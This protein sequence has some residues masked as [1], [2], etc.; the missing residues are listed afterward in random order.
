M[1]RL[2]SSSSSSSDSESGIKKRV[3][4]LTVHRQQRGEIGAFTKKLKAAQAEAKNTRGPKFKAVV[5]EMAPVIEKLAADAVK[6]L[7]EQMMATARRGRSE[8]VFFYPPSSPGEQ[9]GSGF[10]N[11]DQVAHKHGIMIYHDD[12][13]ELTRVL[14]GRIKSIIKKDVELNGIVFDIKWAEVERYYRPNI[15]SISHMIELR[16][17]WSE[18]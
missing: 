1:K 8:M 13:K 7:K 9:L 15:N 6:Q 14:G 12:K 18:K 5:A 10:A 4:F 16:A 3:S 2:S 11:L 17:N